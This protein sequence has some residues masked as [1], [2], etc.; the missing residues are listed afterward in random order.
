[1]VTKARGKWWVVDSEGYE[2]SYIGHDTK[3]E[4]LESAKILAA[5]REYRKAFAPE[6]V[7]WRPRY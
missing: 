7:E 6:P 4:A 5:D 3:R 1:M 2:V